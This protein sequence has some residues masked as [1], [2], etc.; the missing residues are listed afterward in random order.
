MNNLKQALN[1]LLYFVTSLSS[2]AATTHLNPNHQ[3]SG[4]SNQMYVNRWA[5][6]KSPYTANDLKTLFLPLGATAMVNSQ[7]VKSDPIL[8]FQQLSDQLASLKRV[9]YHYARMFSYPSE[10]YMAKDEGEMYI[11]FNKED[12]LAGM[13]FQYDD[14]RSTVIFNNAELF[15]GNKKTQTLTLYPIKSATHLEGKSPLYNSIVTLRNI[16]PMV[17]KD[18]S[19]Q[20]SVSDTLINQKR[21][22]QLRFVLHNKLINYMGTDYSKVTKEL[23]FNYTVIVDQ[24]T[25]LPVTILQTKVNS[26]DLNRTDFTAI[27]TSP[28]Q[29]LE[30]SWFYSNYLDQYTL[31][32]PKVPLVPIKVGT[33][34]PN[35]E[36]TNYLSATKE[37][38]SQHRGKLVLL[39]F[40]IKN[41]GFCIEAVDKLNSLHQTYAKK[42]FKLLGINTEDNLNNIASFVNKHPV[43]YSILYGDNPQLNKDYGIAIFPQVVLL[44][45]NGTVLYSGGLDIE[46]LKVLI[47]KNL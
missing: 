20:K 32:A 29:V 39:E 46:K 14:S 13:R 11:E 17:I 31:Q 19:I 12:D 36:L 33:T 30:K 25:L 26:Q 2:F 9:K 4:K 6:I 28:V 40:W 47:D 34:A 43:N 44:A 1:T 16:L 15:N 38:L 5:S 27:E 23:T 7:Y 8:I 35:W 10:D 42:N 24:S 22:H 3:L 45:K 18:Q 41:C 21:Y 37:T